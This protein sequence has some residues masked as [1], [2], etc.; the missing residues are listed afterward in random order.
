MEDNYIS[1]LPEAPVLQMGLPEAPNL[2][3]IFQ[4]SLPQ[5]T[6]VAESK[7]PTREER[8]ASIADNISN[9]KL[10]SS[11][12]PN[13]LA[14]IEIGID[15]S[16]YEGVDIS[17]AKL[18][19]GS[20]EQ[21][22]AQTQSYWDRLW[23]DTKVTGA[24]L[25]IGFATAF[26]SIYD[27]INDGSFI[28]GE[29]SA[30]SN[31]GRISSK[32]AEEN[33]NFQTQY[34]VD[35]PIKSLLLP[36]F[37]T[38]SSKGWGEIAKSASI[39]IGTGAGIIVQELGIGAVTGGIGSIPILANN[40]R[41][42]IRG[43]KTIAQAAET[44]SALRAGTTSIAQGIRELGAL[45][46]AISA[47]N[48]TKNIINFGK[49]TVRGAL[50]AYGESAF[51]AQESR[52]SFTLDKIKEYK[53]KNGYLPSGADLDK[54]K[55]VA[56]QAHDARFLLNFGL[57]TFSNMPFNN[58]IFKQFDDV[59]SISE[60]AA[61]KGLKYTG[62]AADGFEK[63]FQLTSNW[64]SKNA[65]TKGMKT[66][67]ETGQPYAKNIFTGKSITWSEGL[68][69]GYQFWVDKAT[70]NY[71]NTIYNKGTND[72][73]D[74]T[75][76]DTIYGLANSF[77]KTK[78]QLI[79]TEGLQNII[80]GIMG[81]TGQSVFSKGLDTSK[82]AYQASKI[83][84]DPKNNTTFGEEY[85]KL[86]GQWKEGSQ[87]RIDTT[88]QI[89]EGKKDLLDIQKAINLNSITG[90]LQSKI[91]AVRGAYTGAG[92][93][94][95]TNSV[96][97]FEKLKDITRFHT[98]AP[99]VMRGQSDILKEQLTSTLEDVSDDEFKLMTGL[100]NITPG[101]KQQYISKVI[102]DVNK[103]EKSVKRNL[104]TFR[105]KYQKGT[106]EYDLYEN[107]KK[108]FAF[109]GYMSENMME[110]KKELESKNSILFNA[111]NITAAL[112]LATQGTNREGLLDQ[113]K[114]R[115][116]Q[117]E[118]D[119]KIVTPVVKE[120]EKSEIDEQTQ[121]LIAKT[122][123]QIDT[124]TKLETR[125]NGFKGENVKEVIDLINDVFTSF[126]Q[127]ELIQDD[128]TLN[129]QNQL[130]KILNTFTDHQILSSN[131]AEHLETYNNLVQN[132]SDSNKLKEALDKYKEQG[133][134]VQSSF[135]GLKNFNTFNSV[136][137]YFLEK[138]L[139][140]GLPKDSEFFTEIMKG[141]QELQSRNA[142]FEEF[143]DLIDKNIA[144]FV[145]EEQQETS[146]ENGFDEGK[147][148]NESEE[149]LNEDLQLKS[150]LLTFKTSLE[151][152]NLVKDSKEYKNVVDALED[153]TIRYNAL[154]KIDEKNLSV[155]QKE[156]ME[157]FSQVSEIAEKV[158]NDAIPKSAEFLRNEEIDEELIAINGDFESGIVI[159]DN[160]RYKELEQYLKDLEILNT[161]IENQKEN[162]NLKTKNLKNINYLREKIGNII[163]IADNAVN[164]TDIDDSLSGD[165]KSIQLTKEQIDSIN[166]VNKLID[167]GNKAK[168]IE[169][170]KDKESHYSFLGKL[171]QRVT[172]FFQE[173]DIFDDTDT[174]T[175]L[176]NAVV[177]G[178]YFDT[179]ARLYYN[180]PN[181]TKEEFE[182]ALKK[183]KDY[184]QL[185]EIDVKVLF[186]GSK[187][188]F[189]NI[190]K[191]IQK[192]LNDNNLVFIT[193]N[194]FV[195]S[196]FK[197]EEWAGVAGTL[198]MVVVDSKGKVY[199]YDFKTK[200]ENSSKATVKGIE[201]PYKDQETYQEK[202][203]KQ[204][205]AYSRLFKDTFGYVP[206]INII[207]IPITYKKQSF[208]GK[209]DSFEER[210]KFKPVPSNVQFGSEPFIY[211]L[212]YDENNKLV[213]VL[214]SLHSVKS[215][216]DEEDIER[217]RKEELDSIKSNIKI[218][219][220]KKSY[221]WN[222]KEG[223]NTFNY[224]V[225]TSKQ[226]VID[227]INAKYDA[228]LEALRNQYSNKTIEQLE[229]EIADLRAQEKAELIEKIPN[230]T[231]VINDN[232]LDETNFTDEEKAIA[233]EIY[234]RYNDP[235]TFLIREL[236]AKKAANEK[237]QKSTNEKTGKVDTGSI[238]S[239]TL[240]SIVY[241]DENGKIIS[242]KSS[243][244]KEEGIK[245]AKKVSD[246]LQSGKE[247][248]IKDLT[249]KLVTSTE[250]ITT[251]LMWDKVFKRTSSEKAIQVTDSS[252]NFITL[253]QDPKT[254]LLNT[255]YILK[256]KDIKLNPDLRT[257]L[258]GNPDI[259]VVDA[260]KKKILYETLFDYLKTIKTITN[261]QEHS[262]LVVTEN[263]ET[264]KNI[265]LK[266]SENFEKLI[267]NPEKLKETFN[268][269]Y[270]GLETFANGINADKE[271][272]YK[273]VSF[274]KD[275]PFNFIGE[276]NQP[277]FSIS[278][279]EISPLNGEELGVKRKPLREKINNVLKE[280]AEKTPNFY[281][282]L[283]NKGSY[284]TVFTDQNNKIWIKP[285]SLKL[286]NSKEKI[287]EQIFQDEKVT[288][289][290][291]GDVR[292]KYNITTYHNKE[293]VRIKI[294]EHK[295]D[296]TLVNISFSKKINGETISYYLNDVNKKNLTD[297]LNDKLKV[298]PKLKNKIDGLPNE[299]D[300][301]D[302]KISII[303]NSSESDRLE[304]ITNGDYSVSDIDNPISIFQNVG[305]R[306]KFNE[307]QEEQN[308]IIPKSFIPETPP[309]TSRKDS[310]KTEMEVKILEIEERRKA[311]LE[312]TGDPFDSLSSYPRIDGRFNAIYN[313]SNK[314][315]EMEIFDT[316]QQAKDWIN[317][318]YNDEIKAVKKQ[319][320]ITAD[321]LFA[322]TSPVQELANIPR[323]NIDAEKKKLENQPLMNQ[324]E[325]ETK[326]GKDVLTNTPLK[327]NI[328]QEQYAENF[329]T[330]LRKD[331]EEFDIPEPQFKSEEDYNT[332]LEDFEERKI[333]YENSLQQSNTKTSLQPTTVNDNLQE[334]A[335]YI[336]NNL[337]DPKNSK[338][339]WTYTVYELK[340]DLNLSE[341]NSRFVKLKEETKQI[342]RVKQEFLK[343]F[344]NKK[345]I[346]DYSKRGELPSQRAFLE[347]NTE[348]VNQFVIN[349]K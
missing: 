95:E 325:I 273:E 223:K 148:F 280:I 227:K 143:K 43:S 346:N 191:Q 102:E 167:D 213:V 55:K 238:K 16:K 141:I 198:D 109:H 53:E 131:L 39:G 150:D 308:P 322:P 138:A 228:E 115:K 267:E 316:Y 284:F 83:A 173:G 236:K 98:I 201:T 157:L 269:L 177:V 285:I 80:G 119:I 145:K 215:N 13:I 127:L 266:Q 255:K 207:V 92:L 37:L 146:D 323:E 259:S 25:G 30:T 331:Y 90:D 36:S 125:V 75:I 240:E 24:N 220:G 41:N 271:G 56:E 171:Y 327:W 340:N 124:L 101:I 333:Q 313:M 104:S 261:K 298:K 120:G 44:A 32:F 226:E 63:S 210:E 162:S 256:N 165:G 249:F 20:M 77:Y 219:N 106:D 315:N 343:D 155:I 96:V 158:I 251:P 188:R 108:V 31:L 303:K 174:V 72:I 107:A 12:T 217:R 291:T 293:L 85:K 46:G 286:D 196:N 178:N 318:K 105:N 305:F 11:Y 64:W 54:I 19:S 320:E 206:D 78:E 15:T 317:N 221:F 70:N 311:N 314:E 295:F 348:I 111:P 42:L 330:I 84:S 232:V 272:N 129:L 211:K 239:K 290:T 326:Y 260:I 172:N 245:T 154:T 60:Q 244:G 118:S 97:T 324:S 133:M 34:D 180:N 329:N 247:I 276:W 302:S 263:F 250:K 17:L 194:I 332:Y 254:L 4:S 203:T 208:E 65:V 99:M 170:K 225:S 81:G 33:T 200:S 224:N 61:A 181:L 89:E 38:G 10:T 110:R 321:E 230:Q 189:S 47:G 337:T 58:S 338:G 258:E 139:E 116:N 22:A 153:L 253:I 299:L 175:N 335:D 222:T 100:E 262:I 274:T 184:T 151:N 341:L 209:F 160:P 301:E 45:E 233:K 57:L 28:P 94:E 21:Y 294:Y 87:F 114:Q 334:I 169:A 49:N 283:I 5:Y 59:M 265:M 18:Q 187:T 304:L 310:G 1:D 319:Y 130:D 8:I 135:N 50:S 218:V 68:E 182:I 306:L 288:E 7:E 300:L 257:L 186:E 312:D 152:L 246:T 137:E 339:K 74:G 190:K 27:M 161:E 328:S 144:Q 214:N 67:L 6:R 62:K 51:E 179:F 73:I 149:E 349:C 3:K 307:K 88:S 9:S 147:I 166:K 205:T 29:D 52:D 345:V 289:K 132:Y 40:I 275:L 279:N 113:I 159:K 71:Y 163:Q 342:A 296:K 140:V 278:N 287:E 237:N 134:I 126:N 183:R 168:L 216:V 2:D 270:S 264:F 76:T 93:M 231:I 69:E 268:E 26:T 234:D 212:K 103:V 79:S 199:I 297:I 195:H 123:A 176:M 82:L 252:N 241:I 164:E 344:T 35:N 281:E 202:W 229:K 112:E 117:F 48:T 136:K 185:S 66:A 243:D 86:T 309:T 235:I 128:S 282:V 192:D 14:P 23:N 292:E 142:E 197:N 193:D 122:Q 277:I 242:L 91:E 121:Q 156:N 204:Q 347:D 336:W 248:D